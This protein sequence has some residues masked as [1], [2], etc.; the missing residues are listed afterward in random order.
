MKQGAQRRVRGP[1]QRRG[2][3]SEEKKGVSRVCIV[4]SAREW[5]WR[6]EMACRLKTWESGRSEGRGAAGISARIPEVGPWVFPGLQRGSPQIQSLN[7]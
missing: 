1:E 2:G 7:S 3:G 5:E 6:W 4:E